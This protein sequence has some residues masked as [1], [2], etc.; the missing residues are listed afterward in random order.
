LGEVAICGGDDLQVVPTKV[1]TFEDKNENSELTRAGLFAVLA[2]LFIG[3][4]R[5]L[6]G[7]P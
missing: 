6:T 3:F 5:D 2:V 7:S 4:L 1:T